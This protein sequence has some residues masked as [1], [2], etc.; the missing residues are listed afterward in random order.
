M[1][2]ILLIGS[3]QNRYDP[4]DTGGISILFELLILELKK[5]NIS[6]KVIDTLVTN[7]G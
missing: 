2:K 1:S 7:N 5:E 3:R 6:F 4:T